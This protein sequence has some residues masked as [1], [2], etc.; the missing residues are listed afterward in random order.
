MCGRLGRTRQETL[1][2]QCLWLYLV[3][4]VT[5]RREMG[6][7]APANWERIRNRDTSSATRQRQ[8]NADEFTLKIG[9]ILL[10][11]VMPHLKAQ[12]INFSKKQAAL[13]L[14]NMEVPARRGGAWTTTQVTR[15]FERLEALIKTNSSS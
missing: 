7:K 13:Y 8:L 9:D 15:V 6:K 12:R 10:H 14:N 2:I 4:G 3:M 5:L 11:Q 1:R